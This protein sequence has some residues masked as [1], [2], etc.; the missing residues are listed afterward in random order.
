[1]LIP[2]KVGAWALKED[3]LR[4][5]TLPR[6]YEKSSSAGETPRHEADHGNVHQR[7]AACTRPLVV[8]RLILLCWSIY[9][10]VRFTT[11]LL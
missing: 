6:L 4:R 5:I 2:G 10:N 9:A 8:Y 7:L 1:M 11:H 3:E